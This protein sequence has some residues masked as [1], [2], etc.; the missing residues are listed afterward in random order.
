MVGL[1]TG[2][3]SES[4]QRD[5]RETFP[6]S[7]QNT[8]KFQLLHTGRFHFLGT[9]I[10]CYDLTLESGRSYYIQQVY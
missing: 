1:H 7:S 3:T 9:A 6:Y 5:P 2:A 4:A 10:G 8:K